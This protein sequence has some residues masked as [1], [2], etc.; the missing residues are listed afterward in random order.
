MLGLHQSRC[1]IAELNNVL[2]GV[3]I[4]QSLSVETYVGSYFGPAR[5]RRW[6]NFFGMGGQ[7][8]N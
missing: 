1:Q 3:P 8:L 4:R 5:P 6:K 2:E 7:V